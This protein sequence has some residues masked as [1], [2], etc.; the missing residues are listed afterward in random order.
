MEDGNA[1]LLLGLNIK[2]LEV[3]SLD[4]FSESDPSVEL[5][6]VRTFIALK[7]YG[8]T[9]EI[10]LRDLHSRLFNEPFNAW[11]I[12]ILSDRAKM[13]FNSLKKED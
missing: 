4:V 1:F 7:G 5:S 8:P 10:A 9:F 11:M 12:P 2:T 6:R 13:L 3:I